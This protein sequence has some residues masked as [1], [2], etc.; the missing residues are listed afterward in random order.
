MRVYFTERQADALIDRL[1]AYD[2]IADALGIS[3]VEA[4]TSFET[5]VDI[6]A[7][8]LKAA[9]FVSGPLS[10]MEKAILSDCI[11]GS[12]WVAKEMDGP[13]HTPAS[14]GAY[15]TLKNTTKKLRELG[16]EVNSIPYA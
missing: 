12:T 7:S 11:E 3:G 9:K 8:N 16:V 14:I 5:C 6:I 2:A 13:Y 4:W 1:D 10:E 15:R